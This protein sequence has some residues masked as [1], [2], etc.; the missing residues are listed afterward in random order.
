MTF[1]QGFFSFKESGL[2]PGQSTV[3]TITL[4]SRDVRLTEYYKYGPTADSPT[5]H[6]YAFLYNGSTGAE[7]I[8]GSST[9]TIKLHLVDRGMGDDDPQANGEITDAGGPAVRAAAAIHSGDEGG[10][11]S[12]IQ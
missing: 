2:N 4:H 9:T 3:L 7:I 12:C 8:Q 1:P 11:I 10:F 6:W 5:N